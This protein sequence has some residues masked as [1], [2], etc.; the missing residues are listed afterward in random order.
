MIF[1][2]ESSS[3]AASNAGFTTLKL[4][5]NQNTSSGTPDH[6]FSRTTGSYSGSGNV[7]V[8]SWSVSVSS[9][10]VYSTFFGSTNTTNYYMELV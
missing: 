3:V 4:W 5:L 8:W 10:S 7:R 6:T 2:V 9:G 1:S